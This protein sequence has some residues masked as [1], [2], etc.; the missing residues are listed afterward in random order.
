MNVSCYR[1]KSAFEWEQ[2]PNALHFKVMEV[3]TT[4]SVETHSNSSRKKMGIVL[5]PT[6]AIAYNQFL[7]NKKEIAK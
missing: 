1:C 5:C 7:L 6:C 2:S 3:V 4:Y